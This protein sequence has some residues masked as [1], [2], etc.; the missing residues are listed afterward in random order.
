MN[1]F[2]DHLDGN[3]LN[4]NIENLQK[5]THQHNMWNQINA[6][7]Y[8]WS[9]QK[10]KYQA[11]ICVNSKNK[12]LGYFDNEIDARNCYLDAKKIHHKI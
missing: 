9:K 6:K 5:K 10:N 7:G 3:K 2:I 4:N 12:H 1:N 8:S 11:Q